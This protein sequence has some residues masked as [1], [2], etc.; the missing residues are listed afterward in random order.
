MLMQLAIP[1]LGGVGIPVGF[2]TGWA[3]GY[4]RTVL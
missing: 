3:R 4:K 1:F 2:G